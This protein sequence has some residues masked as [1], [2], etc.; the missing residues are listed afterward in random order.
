MGQLIN[1]N[2]KLFRAAQAA[3]KENAVLSPCFGSPTRW[4]QQSGTCDP[5]A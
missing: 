2:N 3:A 4:T 1:K 5:P